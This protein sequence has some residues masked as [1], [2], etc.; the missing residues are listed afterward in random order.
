MWASWLDGMSCHSPN[1]FKH[2]IFVGLV[3]PMDKAKIDNLFRYDHLPPFLQKVSKPFHDM[4]HLIVELN[5]PS[6]EQTL[7]LRKLWEAKNL[8]VFSAVP[9]K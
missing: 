6:A 1:G 2:S 7:A 8:V 3:G 5:P 9:P 4:A